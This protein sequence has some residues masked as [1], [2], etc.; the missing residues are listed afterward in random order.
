MEKAGVGLADW[1]VLYFWGIVSICIKK[2]F[3][4]HEKWGAPHGFSPGQNKHHLSD[5]F[6]TIMNV[7][8]SKGTFL[9]MVFLWIIFDLI[10]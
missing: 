2:V 3:V 10:C 8:Q 9:S 1:N 6:E 4:V 5:S 7:L